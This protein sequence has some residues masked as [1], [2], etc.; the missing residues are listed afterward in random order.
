IVLATH[1]RA[2]WVLD[3]AEPIQEYAA[4]RNSTA[5]LFTPPPASMYRRPARD[6]NYEFWGNQ[7]FYGENPPQAAVI[8]YF[9][10]DKPGTVALKIADTAGREVREIAIPAASL[11]AGVDSA[12]WDLRVQPIAA[13]DLGRGGRGDDAQQGRGGAGGANTPTE[14]FG[15]GCGGGAGFGG[16]G[17][18][19]GGGFGGGGGGTPGPFV[20]PGSYNVSLV[21]DGKTVETKP[22]RVVG[23]PEVV[24]TEAQR[25]SLF[26]MAMEMHDLQKR[27]GEAA[28]GVA[29]LNR[30][31]AQLTNDLA[32]KSDVP[33]DVK[34]AFDALKTETA[35]LL[36]KLPPGGGAA[37]GR[38]GGGGGRGGNDPSV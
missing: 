3:H 9:T 14:T 27:A 12:C 26:D 33:A 2:I 25:K 38:G 18:G 30:Q 37:A 10:K 8:S 1:G 19:G 15:F 5:K 24:L 28:A 36:T 23:D 20:L 7:V 13:P 29:S 32:A 4:A 34:S 11:R 31:I 21:V 22:L 35:A 17:G 6:R 16:G